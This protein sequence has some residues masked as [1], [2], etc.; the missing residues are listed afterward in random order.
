MGEATQETGVEGENM[1]K[2][3][4]VK[5]E[6]WEEKISKVVN[7]KQYFKKSLVDGIKSFNRSRR[8]RTEVHRYFALV[9]S[10]PSLTCAVCLARS[11]MTLHWLVSHCNRVFASA[12]FFFLT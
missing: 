12:F 10:W 1:L 2:E 9:L 7:S 6:N 5:S 4:L 8:M 3:Q 11:Y